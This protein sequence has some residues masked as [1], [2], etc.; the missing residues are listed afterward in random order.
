MDVFSA[1]PNAITNE[2]ELGQVQRAT[3]V[4]DIFSSIG[5]LSVIADEGSSASI[6]QSPNADDLSSDTMLFVQPLELPTTNPAE[7]MAS[8][9]WYNNAEGQ[10]YEIIDVGVGKNQ[11]TGAVEH[12]EMKLRQTEA[13]YEYDC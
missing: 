2:W 3:E 1:F 7:L 8:Y 13:Q 4:G 5:A 10:F 9:I 11:E 12:I 6:H